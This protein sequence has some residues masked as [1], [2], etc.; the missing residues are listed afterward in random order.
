VFLT[1]NFRACRREKREN[2]MILKIFLKTRKIA[3]STYVF[4][5]VFGKFSK[6]NIMGNQNKKNLFEKVPSHS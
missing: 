1:K 5:Q 3:P 6:I 2:K 4:S